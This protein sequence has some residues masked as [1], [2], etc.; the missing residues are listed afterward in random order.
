MARFR[1][2][3]VIAAIWLTFIFNIERPDFDIFGTESNID[4]DTLTYV[5]AAIVAMV[6]L[7]LP[8]ISQRSAP[9]I[10]V[11]T[12]VSYFI[13]KMSF[14]RPISAT[15]APIIALEI[16]VIYLTIVLFRQISL[17]LLRFEQTVESVLLR[18]DELRVLPMD[19]GL[20][21]LQ[22]EISRARRFDRKVGVVL[23]SVVTGEELGEEPQRFDLEDELRKHYIQLRMAQVTELVLYKVD[24]VMLYKFDVLV[25]IPEIT[26][27]ALQ[28]KAQEIQEEISW[29][30]NIEVATGTAIFPEDGFIYRDLIDHATVRMY[31]AAD[32]LM[33]QK[34]PKTHDDGNGEEETADTPIPN[35]EEVTLPTN[36]PKRPNT[37]TAKVSAFLKQ[38]KLLEQVFYPWPDVVSELHKQER[39][40]SA[41]RGEQE[42]LFDPN[43]WL[44]TLPYQSES[45]RQL[46]NVLKRVFDVTMVSLSLPLTL[47]VMGA[48][49]L[50]IWLEDRHSVIFVQQR[51]GFGGRRFGMYKF[52]SMVPDAEAKLKELAAQGLAKLD[53]NGK[54][55][56]PLKLE[57]DPRITRIGWILRKTSL[58]ELPQLFNV[59][60]GD[61]SLIGPRPTS[62]GVDSYRLIHTERLQVRPGI[63][64]LW[65]VA[66]RGNTNFDEWVEWDRTY[67]EKMCVSLDTQILMRT[68][69]KVFK[70]RGA[71]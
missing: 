66:A 55:A 65:Q 56:E 11:P 71:R 32:K 51:T 31:E 25:C 59:L 41:R 19:K 36:A 8:D 18:P 33:S 48:V 64:G 52:R 14:G 38:P 13:L 46:Y 27:E 5:L 35:T 63:T 6:T 15:T 40:G 45:A 60:K 44:G 21:R 16:I 24:S 7:W 2:L 67:V 12:L 30:L 20:E 54:L 58:D 34:T 62:W 70:Q 37:T 53:A 10:F 23:V 9:F 1:I 28:R 50:L 39:Y 42:D 22:E 17:A 68:L 61:M 3:V 43:S 69:L 4:L 49:A 47:P 29:R 57:R 26:K